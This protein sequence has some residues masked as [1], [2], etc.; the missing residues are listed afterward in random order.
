MIFAIIF[1]YLLIGYFS[2]KIC[3]KYHFYC[4]S[5]LILSPVQRVFHALLWP[6]HLRV[7]GSILKNEQLFCK[8]IDRIWFL[9]KV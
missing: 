2:Q 4:A 8:F 7:L 5:K 9:F 3:V 1:I 6:A